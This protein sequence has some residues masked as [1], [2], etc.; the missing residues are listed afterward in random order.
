MAIK[1]FMNLYTAGAML[2]MNMSEVSRIAV[3][4]ITKWAYPRMRANVFTGYQ[5]F[6]S[7]EDII[8]FAEQGPEIDR[9]VRHDVEKLVGTKLN[10]DTTLGSLI[11]EKK[12]T[13]KEAEQQQGRP[14]YDNE[15]DHEWTLQGIYY[16]VSEGKLTS[17]DLDALINNCESSKQMVEWLELLKLINSDKI[18][19]VGDNN[20]IVQVNLWEE[21]KKLHSVGNE[22]LQ[23][24]SIFKINKEI[25]TD[26]LAQ[27]KFKKSLE[28]ILKRAYNRSRGYNKVINQQKNI[29]FGKSP[30]KIK[31]DELLSGSKEIIKKYEEYKSAVNVPYVIASNPHYL[32][33]LKAFYEN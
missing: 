21:L 17:K 14:D 16:L 10:N 15:L 6:K 25:S 31:I 5:G 2:G 3:S 9:D 18:R 7:I 8:R 26:I 11:P 12:K 23:L 33:Y 22:L 19:V 28:D 1:E 27:L 4:N 32:G 29:E 13:S 30:G 20:T 24:S